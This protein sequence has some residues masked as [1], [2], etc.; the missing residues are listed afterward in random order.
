MKYFQ[1]LLI[2]MT[3]VVVF[4]LSVVYS[5]IEIPFIYQGF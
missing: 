3:I 2:S 1:E 5:G 4:F